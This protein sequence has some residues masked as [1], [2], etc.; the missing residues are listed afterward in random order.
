VL[1]IDVDISDHL[2]TI[3]EF[4]HWLRNKKWW[5]AIFLYA[6]GVL[7][8]NAY[9]VYCS[10][11]DEAGVER[12]LRKTH[13]Q[14]LLDIATSWI[15][16]KEP[17]IR[18]VVKA[19]GKRLNQAVSAYNAIDVDGTPVVV[20]APARGIMTPT[21]PNDNRAN[22]RSSSSR[23]W[24]ISVS[25]TSPSPARKKHRVAT[26]TTAEIAIESPSNADALAP[27][28][29]TKALDPKKGS[30]SCRLN[31][32]GLH[33]CPELPPPGKVF[34]CALHRWFNRDWQYKEGI[35]TCT[36]CRVNLCVP[37]FKL[38]HAEADII[39]KR[40][41]LMAKV[42]KDFKERPRAKR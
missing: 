1:Y 30:L 33:H 16:L 31:H 4:D 17:D 2:R 13:Y 14:F 36:I 37:C 9:L 8:T 35:V 29:N 15:D 27:R 25:L 24:T 39:G 26:P 22:T 10:V 5:W 19:S 21:P 11:L 40:E 6:M 32:F 7:L 3:Y 12:R 23:T 41:E 34:K 20:H 38:F 28:C 18:D 42:E